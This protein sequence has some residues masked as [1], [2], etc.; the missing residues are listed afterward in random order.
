MPLPRLTIASQTLQDFIDLS[1][2]E[3]KIIKYLLT[4]RSMNIRPA[5][6]TAYMTYQEIAD[7]T[8]LKVRSI[9]NSISTLKRQGWITESGYIPH[10]Q[11]E[12]RKHRWVLNKVNA[13]MVDTYRAEAVESETYRHDNR[14]WRVGGAL[15]Y[16]F[17]RI[18]SRRWADVYEVPE[19]VSTFF[20]E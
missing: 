16:Q 7:A 11:G 19:P 13:D 18:G 10:Q 17:R 3:Q 15:G 1:R 2:A 4:R 12:P 6:P 9:V 5:H 20:A 8:G 14:E